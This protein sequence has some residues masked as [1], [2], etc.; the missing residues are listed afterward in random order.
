MAN[1]KISKWHLHTYD[2]AD[3]VCHASLPRLL[4]QINE[5]YTLTVIK[6]LEVRFHR[7]PRSHDGNCTGEDEINNT[8]LGMVGVT[9]PQ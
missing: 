2:L 4:K 3:A 5:R 6:T 1:T 7:S 8:Q 9:G